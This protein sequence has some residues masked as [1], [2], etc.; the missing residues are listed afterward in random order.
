MRTII[1][2]FFPCP[3]NSYNLCLTAKDTFCADFPSNSRDFAGEYL[4]LIHHSVNNL[5]GGQPGE[6]NASGNNYP[7]KR[8]DF[9]VHFHGVNLDFLAQITS[10]DGSN[11]L[12]DF[13]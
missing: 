12:S 4:K 2:E 1:C 8:C 9:R 3:I 11:N 5:H 13:P 10:S 6:S 7:F